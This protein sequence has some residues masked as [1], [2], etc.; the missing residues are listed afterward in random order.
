MS[1]DGG[2]FKFFPFFHLGHIVPN[3]VDKIC[4][5]K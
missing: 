3:K 2:V 4:N 1:E 5:I